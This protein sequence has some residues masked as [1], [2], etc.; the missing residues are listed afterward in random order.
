MLRIICVERFVAD[1]QNFE[2]HT[3]YKK[4]K[5]K[6]IGKYGMREATSI[7]PPPPPLGLLLVDGFGNSTIIHNRDSLFYL[8]RNNTVYNMFANWTYLLKV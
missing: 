4:R 8:I 3:Y 1:Q 5:A 7:S 2:N 6:H